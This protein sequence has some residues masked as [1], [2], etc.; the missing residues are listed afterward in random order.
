MQALLE[1]AADGF[2]ADTES[3]GAGSESDVQ[4][5][6]ESAAKRVQSRALLKSQPALMQPQDEANCGNAP[7]DSASE[8]P[9]ADAADT[10]SESGHSADAVAREQPLQKVPAAKLH[11]PEQMSLAAHPDE[12]Q[13]SAADSMPEP[14]AQEQQLQLQP[15]PRDA[16][17]PGQD[18][19]AAP[20]PPWPAH[21]VHACKQGAA[22]QQA[23]QAKRGRKRKAAAQEEASAQGA[24]AAIGSGSWLAA[25]GQAGCACVRAGHS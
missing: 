13:M 8:S 15:A 3:E 18:P 17:G 7:V 16:S 14:S 5:E 2:G 22:S 24:A 19:A 6:E 25:R 20:E 4:D 11:P 23:V 9:P 1:T 12:V 10:F 21:D